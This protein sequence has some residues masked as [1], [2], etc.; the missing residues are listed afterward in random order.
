MPS[1]VSI[2]ERSRERIREEEDFIAFIQKVAILGPE[3]EHKR[4]VHTEHCCSIHGCKY[5][6]DCSVTSGEKRQSG[7]C[8]TCCFHNQG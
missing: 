5:F 2:I 3:P 7:P 1:S 4:D 6:K 8:E